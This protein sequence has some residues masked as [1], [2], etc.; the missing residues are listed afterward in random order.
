MPKAPITTQPSEISP[1]AATPQV[2]NADLT[3]SPPILQQP[4]LDLQEAVTAVLNGFETQ[5]RG[6]LIMPSGT[7]R[8]LTALKIAEDLPG[9]GSSAIIYLVSSLALLNQTLLE[10]KCNARNPFFAYA[11]CSDSK[12]EQKSGDSDLARYL[13]PAELQCPAFTD[14]KAMIKQM[15]ADL[16]IL[17][18]SDKDQ[19]VVVFVTYH[20]LQ[21][22]Y[23]F[24]NKMSML[25]AVLFVCEEVHRLVGSHD[26]MDKKRL[27]KLVQ[28]DHVFGLKRLYMSAPPMVDGEAA[29]RQKKSGA[30]V[31][32]ALN[33]E[34]KFGPV[35]YSSQ[36]PY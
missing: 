27:F 12:T 35:F 33:D 18:T 11:L 5:A 19:I 23:D 29:K 22:L 15:W 6:Q 32:H 17:L 21:G 34:S 10:W 8:T 7:S 14:A 30:A 9:N 36:V 20:A 13:T 24:F 3:L 26:N 4:H 16:E 25:R 31:L 1:R 28:D 2:G